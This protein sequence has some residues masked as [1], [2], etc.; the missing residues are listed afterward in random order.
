MMSTSARAD[1]TELLSY[2]GSELNDPRADLRATLLHVTAELA[3]LLTQDIDDRELDSMFDQPP[4]LPTPD[5]PVTPG[6]IISLP[7]RGP[8]LVLAVREEGAL[9]KVRDETGVRHI[10]RK[11]DGWADL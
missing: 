10:Q 5:G 11:P 6:E 9:L 2:V 3:R 1:L 7:G 4:T 8:A